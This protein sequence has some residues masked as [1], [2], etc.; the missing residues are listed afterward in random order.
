[1]ATKNRTLG[2][3]LTASNTDVYTV[4]ARY[5][6]Y[7]SSILIANETASTKTVSLDWYD[8]ATTTFY[9][10]CEATPIDG[11]S[12]VQITDSLILQANDKIRG[13]ASATSS[14]T[15]SVKVE[16]QYLTAL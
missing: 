2:K 13:L 8:S 4:P 3:T 9:T 14:V 15:V 16:E 7:V 5:V 11:N 1:M 6:S 10:I 12:I